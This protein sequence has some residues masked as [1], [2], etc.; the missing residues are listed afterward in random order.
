MKSSDDVNTGKAM[1]H[2]QTLSFLDEA[3]P[4]LG[5]RIAMQDDEPPMS[6]VI[7]KDEKR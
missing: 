4:Q 6:A 1:S 2:S 3:Q 7:I 5:L